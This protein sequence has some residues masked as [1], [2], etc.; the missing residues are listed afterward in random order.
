MLPIAMMLLQAAPAA[1]PP[2]ATPAVASCL[3]AAG[4]VDGTG[5]TLPAPIDGKT[6]KNVKALDKLRKK[7]GGA[8]LMIDGGDFSGWNF[9]S[10]KSPP[11]STCFR[12]TK[13]A[14]SDWSGVAAPGAGFI[15]ADLTGAKLVGAVMP[16]VLLR[17][18]TLA[19]ADAT[20]A[21]FRGG[22][23]DG[24]W[25]ASL[26]NLKLDGAVMAGFRFRCGVT[27]A[28]GCP[29]DRQ[30]I[31][32]VGT[33]FTGAEFSGFSFW[34]AELGGSNFDGAELAL[35]DLA[36]L[37][38]QAPQGTLTVRH[39]ARKV[40]VQGPVLAALARAL[41]AGPQPSA[42]PPPGP[43]PRLAG[44]TLFVSDAL[45]I[46]AGAAADPNWPAALR[47]L[48]QLSPSYLL[49]WV[50]TDKQLSVRGY[51][52][53]EAGGSCRIAADSLTPYGAD[54]YVQMPPGSRRGAAAALIVRGDTA[55][56]AP[57]Q[58]T[59]VDAVRVVTCAGNASFGTMKRVAVDSLTFDALWSAAMAGPPPR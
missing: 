7:A 8:L 47:V 1:T 10:A 40:E 11:A 12:G 25:N 33:D 14:N 20:R 59:A 17:T 21:D 5:A 45:P 37:G 15:G 13:L 49:A 43:A 6:V 53:A 57:D 18:T 22:Q 26:A 50:G 41:A 30:G 39:G 36:Q 52:N 34:G 51:A 54:I 16:S 56:V 32:A 23:L 48:L 46:A 3:A 58:A 28:D 35:A 19:G 31:S 55:S 4:A 9:R 29:F 2:P 44:K 24:G 38:G 27:E 42:P